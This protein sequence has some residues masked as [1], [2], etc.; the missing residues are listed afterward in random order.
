MQERRILVDQHV[1]R[2][3]SNGTPKEYINNEGGNKL[4]KSPVV[5]NSFSV[6]KCFMALSEFSA[7]TTGHKR[8][9]NRPHNVQRLN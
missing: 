2:L 3:K 7:Q 8:S 4:E 9:E 1:T 6:G 5:N